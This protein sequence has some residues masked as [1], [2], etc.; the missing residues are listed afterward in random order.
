MESNAR[1]TSKQLGGK[2]WL[3]TKMSATLYIGLTSE[4][5][6]LCLL[7]SRYDSASYISTQPNKAGCSK[8]VI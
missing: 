2:L 7:S 5:Y 1:L 4:L 8:Y 3:E 6:K